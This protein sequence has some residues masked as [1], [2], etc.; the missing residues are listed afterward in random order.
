[1]EEPTPPPVL[2]AFFIGGKKEPF[3]SLTLYQTKLTSPYACQQSYAKIAVYCHDE[4]QGLQVALQY[5][6]ANK[7]PCDKV[8]RRIME[9]MKP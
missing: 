1:M 3:L 5:L 6:R 4:A 2:G 7:L 8:E 9:M